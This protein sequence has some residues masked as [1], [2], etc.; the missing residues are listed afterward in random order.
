M[1]RG[2]SVLEILGVFL[3]SSLSGCST[4]DRDWAKAP[5]PA[6]PLDI[7]GRWQG[8]W[9]SNV[10][11]HNGNLRCIITAATPS[12]VH[13]R[14][15]ATYG[16]I[17]HFEYEMDMT[18]QRRGQWVH[19]EGQADLG[20]LAGGI[21]HYAGDANA[22]DYFATYRSDSDHGRFTMKRPGGR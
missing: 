10:G 4:F 6:N 1:P 3:L 9:Q 12:A 20:G 8:T 13:V 19:F 7:Q 14:Y 16:G 22:S 17:F 21:Y 2:L 11:E 18:C 15:A 5:E